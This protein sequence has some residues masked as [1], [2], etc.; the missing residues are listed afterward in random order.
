MAVTRPNI[1]WRPNPHFWKSRFGLHPKWIIVHGTAGGNSAQNVAGWLERPASES[2]VHFI[3]GRDGLILQ[4]VNLDDS[5]WGNGGITG[6]PG[7]SGDGVH[8]DSWWNPKVNPNLLTISIEHVKSTTDNSE[9]LSD[10]QKIASFHLIAWICESMGIPKHFA[11]ATGGVTGHFSMDPDN[12]SRCPGNYPWSELWSYLASTERP[13]VPVTPMPVAPTTKPTP[14]VALPP[15]ITLVLPKVAEMFEDGGKGAWKSKKTGFY[16]HGA[17]LAFYCRF[18][19]SAWNGATYLGHPTSNEI[20]IEDF[21]VIQRFE[22]GVVVWNPK[23]KLAGAPDG[24][25]DVYLLPLDSQYGEDPRLAPLNVVLAHDKVLIQDLT[26]QCDTLTG[27]IAKLTE[28]LKQA[29]ANEQFKP[30]AIKVYQALGPL[31]PDIEALL[32]QAS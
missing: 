15:S 22:N 12:R 1:V 13:V 9:G 27:Q 29:Q 30:L 4:T 18:G 17:I 19:A 21:L 23:R 28:Q 5:A 16:V 26:T 24:A 20:V 11:D 31:M 6:I 7:K 14:V 8:H 10:A 32:N 25:G 3:I 2:S